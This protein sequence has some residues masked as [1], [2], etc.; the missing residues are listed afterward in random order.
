MKDFTENPKVRPNGRTGPVLPFH[1]MT[2]AAGAR[3]NLACRYCYYLE[4]E[5][6]LYP[7]PGMPR[8]DDATLEC[9]VRDYI[10]AQPIGSPAVFAWQGGEPTLLGLGFYERA[11]ALQKRHAGARRVQNA[12]QTN[13][14][15]LNDEWAAFFRREDFLVGISFDGP[16]ALHDSYRVDRQGRATWSRVREGLSA[17]RRHGVAFNTLTVV[18]RRN[19]NHALEIY[20]FLVKAG[21]RHLQFIPL[22]ERRP[23]PVDRARGLVHA[24]PPAGPEDLTPA[25]RVA[26]VVTPETVPAGRYGD[27]LNTVFDHWVANDVGRVYVQQFESAF[28]AVCGSGP[29]ICVHQ[30]RCGRSFA[31]EHDGALYACDHYVYPE[32][33]MGSIRET[34]LAELAEHPAGE[35]LGDMKADLPAECLECPVLFACHGDCPKHRFV[36]TGP[37]RPGLSY[38]CGDYRSFFTHVQPA[39][40]VMAALL[41][42]GRAPAEIMRM[43]TTSPGKCGQFPSRA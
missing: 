23:R 11:V 15:L 22:V 31:L 4:K 39:M 9:F 20:A 33:R 24:A 18:H 14:T 35:R 21:A 28:S 27:F 17:L 13:G 30:A 26:G 5:P 40:R 38:L 2:K 8:M 29:T 7:E 34:P 41:Q 12:F 25:D 16:A 10:A 37:G 19:C 6:L 1:V 43:G 42:A 3:C 32:Y 36:S